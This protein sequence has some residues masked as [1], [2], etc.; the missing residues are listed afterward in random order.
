MEPRRPDPFFEQLE[1]GLREGVEAVN[2]G[3]TIPAAEVWRH[4][5]LEPKKEDDAGE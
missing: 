1:A 2:R 3:E 4:F 5:G